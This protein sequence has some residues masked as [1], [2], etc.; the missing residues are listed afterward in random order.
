MKLRPQVIISLSSCIGNFC[1]FRPFTELAEN[2]CRDDGRP[3]AALVAYGRLGRVRRLDDVTADL[4]GVLLL[5]V[6]LVRVERGAE[7]RRKHVCR[8]VFGVFAGY[9]VILPVAVMLGY[10]AVA[11][12]VF[13]Q[14]DAGRR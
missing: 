13:R 6:A 4:P 12:G 8:E 11:G 2:D 7:G 9:R 5:V 3:E 1:P 14:G 10:V